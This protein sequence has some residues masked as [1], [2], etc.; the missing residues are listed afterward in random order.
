MKRLIIVLLSVSV[1]SA[2]QTS[3]LNEDG[4]DDS[5]LDVRYSATNESTNQAANLNSQLGAGYISNGSY[6]RALLKLNKALR[7][8]PNHVMAHNYL[9]V[10]YGRLERPEKA[11]DQFKKAMRLAPGNTSVM[12]N[13]AV[14]LCEQK[15]FD[16]A[17]KLFKRVLNNPVYANR[18][19]AY[20]SAAWCAYGSNNYDLSEKLYHEAITINSNLPRSLLG[21]ARVNY[22]KENFQYAWSY[23]ERYYKREVPDADALWLGINI[24]ENMNNPDKNLLSSFKL[25]LKSRYPDTDETKWLYQGKQEY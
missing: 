3:P 18:A 19:S 16:E 17:Q 21:M 11:R 24:L 4:A 9:G 5:G 6:E 23:F 10:L 7:L 25:Q 8:E 13:Y 20:Q 14:F 12:N 2:C 22:K 1:L 15:Q